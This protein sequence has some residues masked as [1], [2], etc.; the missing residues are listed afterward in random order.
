MGSALVM[1]YEEYRVRDNPTLAGIINK[2]AV[3]ESKLQDAKNTLDRQHWDMFVK[4][5]EYDRKC[6]AIW[7]G[8]MTNHGTAARSQRD[9][10]V[11]DT[12]KFNRD[13]ARKLMEKVSTSSVWEAD[14]V[15]CATK[16][17]QEYKNCKS[18]LAKELNLDGFKISI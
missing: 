1:K 13:S 2:H 3:A 15:N 6:V 11:N 16:A 7:Y 17:F 9:V 8:K 14:L 5:V 10:W 4:E 12:H 18:R